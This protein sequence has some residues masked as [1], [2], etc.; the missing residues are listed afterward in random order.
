MLGVGTM[1]RYG[2]IARAALKEEKARGKKEKL[3]RD[4]REFQA[5]AIEI[6]ETPPSP[7]GRL[8]GFTVM[9]SVTAAL[10]WSI[11]GRLDVFAA[12][13]GKV[14]PIGQVKVIQ[15]L[16]TGT[17]K[18]VH[19]KQGQEVAEGDLLIELDPTEQTADRTRLEEDLN[20]SLTAALRLRTAMDAVIKGG[21]VSEARLP[22][23]P[24]GGA[25]ASV[26]A[27]QEYVLKQT[28][29]AYDAE[30][31]SFAGDITQKQ[32]E[33]KRI[34]ATVV[35]RLKLISLMEERLGMIES[36]TKTGSASRSTYLERAEM[37]FQQRAELAKDQGQVPETQAAVEALRRRAE[38]RKQA[39]LQEQTKELEDTEKR[40]A[41]VRQ[42]LKKAR[43]KEIQSRLLAPV[44]GSAQQLSVHTIGQVV[45]TGQ[46]LM[47]V[48]PKGTKLE[49]EANLLNR[50]KG[51][52][53]EGQEARIKVETFDFTKYGVIDGVV[54]NVSNDAVSLGQNGQQPGPQQPQ[55]A[56]AVTGALVFP[57][58]IALSRETIRVDGEELRLTPGMSVVAEVKT[59]NRRVIEY[60]LSPLLKLKDEAFRER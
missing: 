45:T 21:E 12:L 32:T 4:E 5:A 43:Q 15:P 34:E 25:S 27:L 18:T 6:L 10:A 9:V 51:F 22:A 37:L 14:V 52:V 1:W 36:L 40:L 16:I 29:L 39:F 57:V 55:A 41:A 17:V 58:H 19:V 54:T 35:E 8:L 42:E 23:A 47:I 7:T 60:L 44:A 50:D 53:R 30:Q 2:K 46:Q 33:L 56:A 3:S 28:L 48:V 11:V 24:D 59:G 20:T 31:R 38:Q 49:V 13:E 26:Q